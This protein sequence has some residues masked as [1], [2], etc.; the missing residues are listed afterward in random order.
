MSDIDLQLRSIHLLDPTNG[1]ASVLLLAAT[2][3]SNALS[4]AERVIESR[5]AG[6]AQP[7]LPL[8]FRTQDSGEYELTWL[9]RNAS[10]GIDIVIRDI[11]AEIVG[12]LVVT[13]QQWGSLPVLFGWI[14]A[15]SVR[16]ISPSSDGAVIYLGGLM[17]DGLMVSGRSD[18]LDWS[19]VWAELPDQFPSE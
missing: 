5:F 8:E 7:A 10:I 19:M 14:E 11:P 12:A 16:V 9:C 17:R 6:G 15:D 13:L 2:S 4:C 1:A 3:A 18:L